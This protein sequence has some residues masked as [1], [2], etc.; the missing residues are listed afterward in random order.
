MS[1]NKTTV[2]ESGLA[3][4]IARYF[5]RGTFSSSVMKFRNINGNRM[6]NFTEIL[7]RNFPVPPF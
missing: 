5:P 7:F 4:L 2:S 6:V 1:R 3:A